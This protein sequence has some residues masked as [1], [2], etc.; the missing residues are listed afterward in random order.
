MS[1]PS[2][3]QSRRGH[4]H[5]PRV[6]PLVGCRS[7]TLTITPKESVF[8][9]PN[10]PAAPPMVVV[11]GGRCPCNTPAAPPLAA[12][13]AHEL[14]PHQCLRGG[15]PSVGQAHA[16]GRAARLR[17]GRVPD[18]RPPTSNSLQEAA[19]PRPPTENHDTPPEAVTAV[20]TNRV[21][22]AYGRRPTVGL[23]QPPRLTPP[24]P[25]S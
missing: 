3:Y 21:D 24:T 1:L 6:L 12:V 25:K 18:H 16:L 17:G 23:G 19:P 9:S 5:L 20:F 11:I 7:K 22:A 2:N 15:A 8:G 13:H 14:R 4:I 10:T